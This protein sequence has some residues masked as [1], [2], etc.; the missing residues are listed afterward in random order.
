MSNTYNFAF[1]KTVLNSYKIQALPEAFTDFFG[2]KNDTLNFSTRTKEEADYGNVRVNVRNAVYPII[3]QL[4]DQSGE[5]IMEK[6][7]TQSGPIDF[8]AVDPG[9]YDLRAIFDANQ[10]RKYDTGNYLLKQQPE[11]VSYFPDLEE[12]RAYYDQVVEFILQ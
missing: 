7:A 8:I 11:R 2:V 9:K 12:V 1:Q 3:L 10:N 5:V 6:Y 4:V